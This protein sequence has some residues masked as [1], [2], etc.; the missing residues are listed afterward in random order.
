MNAPRLL[1]AGLAAVVLLA[2]GGAIGFSVLSAT[3]LPRGPV[4]I[5]WDKAACAHCS[6]HV[7]EPGFAAQLT[8]TA[9]QTLAFD[10]PG[11]LFQY[12]DA[13]RPEVHE[14]WF[15]HR[16]DDRWL[17]LSAVAFAAVGS[18]PMGYGLAAVDPGS[19]GAIDVA[20]AQAACV[21]RPTKEAR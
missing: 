20:A 13:V 3:C 14:A 9:G 11:C 2:V 6:M 5:V 21:A 4:A 1:P 18:S 8:T 7:G 19:A 16:R 17:P 12:L 10:D 15:H